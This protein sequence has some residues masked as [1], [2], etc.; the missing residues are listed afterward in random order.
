MKPQSRNQMI[1]KAMKKKTTSNQTCTFRLTDKSKKKKRLK[2]AHK[3]LKDERKKKH[4]TK[5]YILVAI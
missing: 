1:A 5:I 2:I 4:Q 3:S